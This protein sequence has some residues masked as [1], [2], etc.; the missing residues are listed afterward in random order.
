MKRY[1]LPVLFF[2]SCLMAGGELSKDAKKRLKDVEIAGIRIDTDKNEDRKK[3]EVLE[4][5]TFQNEDDDGE[6]FRMRVVVELKDK[7]KNLYIVDFTADRPSDLDSEYTGEDYWFLDMYH[8][9]L[10]QLK[11]TDY[12]V[13]YGFMDGEEFIL[14]ADDYDDVKTLDELTERT[15]TPFPGKI[16]L[17]HYY[18]Y[19]DIDE[20]EIESVV[21]TL[22]EIKRKKVDSG[23][24]I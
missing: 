23:P 21:R 3:I 19:D 15:K 24:V 18:M 11:V 4:I 16:R 13:Q 8:E 20:G 10:K 14:L 17:K 1:I 9:E 12:A 7:E 2:V 6:G 22:R 5:N